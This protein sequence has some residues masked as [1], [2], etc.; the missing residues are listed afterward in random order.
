MGFIWLAVWMAF[1]YDRLRPPTPHATLAEKL[2]IWQLLRERDTR[3]FSIAKFATDTIWWFY[4]YWLPKFFV[5]R[6]GLNIREM[7]LPLTIVYL[8][9]IAGSI[10]G[11]LWPVC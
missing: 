7:A 8:A 9:A 4:L 1:P 3:S 6:F 2:A 10:G 11:G 5:R